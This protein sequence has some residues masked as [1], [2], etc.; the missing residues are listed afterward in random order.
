MNYFK[1]AVVLVRTWAA[2]WLGLAAI[3]FA[4]YSVATL[5][6]LAAFVPSPGDYPP[7]PEHEPQ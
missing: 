5:N 1:L 2:V 4:W 6:G 7:S 3:G